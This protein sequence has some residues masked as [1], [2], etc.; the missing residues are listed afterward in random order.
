VLEKE[1][2]LLVK[3]AALLKAERDKKMHKLEQHRLKAERALEKAQEAATAKHE[4]EI[5]K[6][7]AKEL[8]AAERRASETAIYS[9]GV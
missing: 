2:L 9:F 8:K 1:R 4:K 6:V 5:K 7:E 3:A